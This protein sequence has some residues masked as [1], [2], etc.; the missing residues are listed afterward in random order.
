MVLF[1]SRP[2]LRVLVLVPVPD[3]LLNRGPVIFSSECILEDALYYFILKS[4]LPEFYVIHYLQCYWE[5]CYKTELTNFEDHG[6]VGEVWFGEDAGLRMVTWLAAHPDLVPPGA[7]ILD[8][9]TGN[10]LTISFSSFPLLE[11]CGSRSAR[12]RKF[13]PDLDL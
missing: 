8:S 3:I 11:C 2:P 10:N 7:S 5:E 12:S 13:F 4:Q 1:Q 6:D 9:G